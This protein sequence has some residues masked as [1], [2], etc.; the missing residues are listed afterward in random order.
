MSK[1][2]TIMIDEQKYVRADSIR[3]LGNT[4]GTPF[5][6]GKAYLIRTVTMCLTGRVIGV[7]GQFLVINDAAWIA[8][9]GRFNECLAKGTANEVEP[10]S[11]NVFV[12]LGGIIDVYEWPHSLLRVVK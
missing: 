4:N 7:V 8:D 3:P 6:V 2:E 11:G 1:P 5:E 10:A 12:G 9:T